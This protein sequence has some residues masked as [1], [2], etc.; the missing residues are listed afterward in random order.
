MVL[1]ILC[2]ECSEDLAEIFPA[3]ELIKN[4]YID[5]QLKSKNINVLKADLKADLIKD[6]SFIL[7]GLNI[8]KHCCRIHILGDTD[9]DNIYY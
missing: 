6:F 9:F 8:T 7:N 1:H 5:E 3:Y 2:P 4:A